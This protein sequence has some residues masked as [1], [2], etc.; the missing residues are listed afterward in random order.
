MARV[1]VMVASPRASFES[2]APAL[3]GA[4]EPAGFSAACC[5]IAVGT[6]ASLEQAG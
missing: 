6:A 3:P 1:F 2:L 5:G 4:A